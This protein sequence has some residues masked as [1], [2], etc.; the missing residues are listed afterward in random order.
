MT[1][2]AKKAKEKRPRRTKKAIAASLLEAVKKFAPSALGKEEWG[3][4]TYAFAILAKT[5]SR[6]DLISSIK[7]ICT[8]EFL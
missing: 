1:V 4:K 7:D 8:Y 3:L 2:K 6:N 5:Q